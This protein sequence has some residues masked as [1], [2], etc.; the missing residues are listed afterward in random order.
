MSEGSEDWNLNGEWVEWLTTTVSR[1]NAGWWQAVADVVRDREGWGLSPK[2]QAFRQT[3]ATS[4]EEIRDEGADLAAGGALH[5]ASCT[6]EFAV[7]A[8][9]Q[10]GAA[11]DKPLSSRP[12]AR[13]LATPFPHNKFSVYLIDSFDETAMRTRRDFGLILRRLRGGAGGPSIDSRSRSGV[14]FLIKVLSP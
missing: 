2:Q 9:L 14:P 13:P 5:L 1:S 7:L 6:N 11:V 10:Y 4:T 3:L 8:L 12:W